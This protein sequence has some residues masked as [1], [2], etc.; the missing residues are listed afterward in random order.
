MHDEVKSRHS[1]FLTPSSWKWLQDK[2]KSEGTSA[3]EMIEQWIR[4]TKG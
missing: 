1:I 2:A 3:S 4:E